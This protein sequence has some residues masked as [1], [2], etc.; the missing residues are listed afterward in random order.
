MGGTKFMLRMF[1]I[2]RKL[3]TVSPRPRLVSQRQRAVYCM[4]EMWTEE[5]RWQLAVRS[6]AVGSLESWRIGEGRGRLVK[7]NNVLTVVQGTREEE[8]VFLI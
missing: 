3:E 7:K 5:N 4:S 6:W 1:C 2:S 8:L